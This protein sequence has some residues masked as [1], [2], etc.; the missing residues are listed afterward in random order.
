MTDMCG[1]FQQLSDEDLIEINKIISEVNK[2]SMERQSDVYMDDNVV[3]PVIKYEVKPDTFVEPSFYIAEKLKT[4]VDVNRTDK[5]SVFVC[6]NGEQVLREMKWGFPNKYHS[7]VHINA[8]SESVHERFLFA[9]PF[10]ATRCVV[11]ATGFYEWTHDSKG[12][13]VDKYFFTDKNGPIMYMAGIYDH[14]T[15]EGE[16]YYAF[17]ILTAA[18][19]DDVKDIHDRMPVC[20]RPDEIF[21]YINDY[22]Y[23]KKLVTECEVSLERVGDGH[24]GGVQL[25]LI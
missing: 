9:K 11:P 1:R 18:A 22:E 13:A 8:R 23:A 10:E 25:S 7:G 3:K 12:R 21:R 24:I 20:M 15:I 19:N 4:A 2:R 6:V 14:F 5:A 16:S 17:C